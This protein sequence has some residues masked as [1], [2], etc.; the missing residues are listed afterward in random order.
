MPLYSQLVHI[1][2][3]LYV[4][5]D[6]VYSRRKVYGSQWQCVA[7]QFPDSVSDG[8]RR[9]AGQVVVNLEQVRLYVG[10]RRVEYQVRVGTTRHFRDVFVAVYDLRY[11]YYFV[12][13]HFD[14]ALVFAVHI[15]LVSGLGELTVN[16]PY[17]PRHALRLKRPTRTALLKELQTYRA[18]RRRRRGLRT[19]KQ[20]GEIWY[21]TFNVPP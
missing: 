18:F 6:Y 9:R 5:E 11:E 10:V 2:T 14:N 13:Q 21:F 1:L 20:L 12:L 8:G 19:A 3:I 15:V 16:G 7:N 17:F 4:N